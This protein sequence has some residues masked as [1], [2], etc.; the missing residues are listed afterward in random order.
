M[1]SR[2]ALTPIFV[3][4]FGIVILFKL[5]QSL[6]ALSPI[7]VTPSGITKLVKLLSFNPVIFVGLLES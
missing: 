5:L 3:T 4:L 2:N 7:S 6:N 1:H